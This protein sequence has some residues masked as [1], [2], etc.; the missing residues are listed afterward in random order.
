[1]DGGG[2]VGSDVW[3]TAGRDG[4]SRVGGQR[5]VGDVRRAVRSGR[6]STPRDVGEAVGITTPTS[7]GPDV[8]AVMI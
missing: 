5:R 4:G 1:M 2:W 8:V 3:T 6:I 7:V